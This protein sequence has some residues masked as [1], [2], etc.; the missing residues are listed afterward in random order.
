MTIQQ[1]NDQCRRG[2]APAGCLIQYFITRA[3]T[4][5][6]PPDVEAIVHAVQHFENFNKHNDPQGEHDF[7]RLSVDAPSQRYEVFFKFDYYNLE[8]N[9]LAENPADYQNTR[10]IM[11]IG[12]MED[13]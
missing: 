2:R 7:A 8:L 13:Y 11:T 9:G 6:P 4:E 5:L 1:I 10:R 3:I 12:M